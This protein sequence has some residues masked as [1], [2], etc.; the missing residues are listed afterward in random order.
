MTPQ[1]RA[2]VE[3]LAELPGHPTVEDIYRSAAVDLPDLSPRSVYQIVADLVELGEIEALDL[4][5]GAA[6]V[7]RNLAHHR[8]LVCGDCGRVEDVAADL[9]DVS[10][11]AGTVH[12]FVVDRADV[13][14][15][16]LCPRCAPGTVPA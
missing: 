4:G 10:V 7:D 3:A 11:P 6:R 16:G 8:H 15:R 2:V 13:V 12:G 1:R 5:L 14:Y 9:A